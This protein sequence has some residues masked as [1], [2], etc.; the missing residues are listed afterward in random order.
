[1]QTRAVD[2]FQKIGCAATDC[3]VA[4]RVHEKHQFLGSGAS[5]TSSHPYSADETRRIRLE[6]SLVSFVRQT[7]GN[8]DGNCL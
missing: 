6:D 1:M 8:N 5:F 3:Y 7:T 2:L 4:T